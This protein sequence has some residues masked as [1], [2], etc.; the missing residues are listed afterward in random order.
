MKVFVAAGIG[1]AKNE[2]INK[3]A[4]DLG[5]LLAKYQNITYVQGGSD[6][7]LMGETLRAFIDSSK[8]IEFLIPEKYYNYDAPKLSELVGGDNFNALK[9]KSEARRLEKII[10]CDEIIILPGGTGTLEELLYCNETLRSKEHKSKVTLVNLDGY[11]NGFLQQIKASL[12]QG[13]STNSTIKFDIVN[14]VNEISLFHLEHINK[15]F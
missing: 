14:N 2:N 1:L 8:N 13:F 12:E 15:E 11:F 10:E 4:R 6:Q 9:M 5:T 3:Q 7:G